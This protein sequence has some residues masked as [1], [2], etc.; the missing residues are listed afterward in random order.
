VREYAARV[1]APV[2][3]ASAKPGLSPRAAS[4]TDARPLLRHAVFAKPVG[5]SRAVV[6][7][8]AYSSSAGVSGAWTR[9][10]AKYPA[11]RGYSPTIAR[12][13]SPRGTVY[14]LSVSG[15][16]SGRNA[17]DMC[18]ALK[19]SGGA[20]FVRSVAGDRPVQLASL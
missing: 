7:L 8:G 11:L 17:Q 18:L 13:D 6:Q 14:R 19:R 20:C 4:L 2:V 3:K 1:A 12:F 16:A 5:N 10:A 15:F 9:V